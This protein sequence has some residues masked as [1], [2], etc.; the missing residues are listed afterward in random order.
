MS[1]IK[2]RN[3]ISNTLREQVV[4]CIFNKNESVREVARL[5][6]LKK[7]TIYGI[8]RVFTDEKRIIK[9]IQTGR[10]SSFNLDQE[11]R[12]C[13]FWKLNADATL[14]EC[15]QYIDSS[16][17]VFDGVKVSLTTIDRI[18]KKHRVTYKQLTRVPHARNTPETIEKRFRYVTD[19]ID[20]ENED[21]YLIYLD[22]FGVNLH[23]RRSRGRAQIG[24]PAIINTPT[25]RGNN[26][27]TCAAISID[28]VVHFKSQFCPFNHGNFLEFLDGLEK[29]LNKE[30]NNVLIMDNVRF[31]HHAL[32][33]EWI[34]R[35][36]LSVLYLPPYSPFLNPIEE[37]FSKVSNSI[38]LSRSENTETLLESVEFAFR[39]IT[40][41]NIRGWFRH[42]RAYH[43]MCLRKEPILK[44]ANDECPQFLVVE[45]PPD[46]EEEELDELL[47]H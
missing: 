36:N 45:R 21:K 16:P 5:L 33:K 32:V 40:S 39:S 42:S 28:G 27:S 44:E 12:I 34:S 17:T 41:E 43:S 26:L 31:H 37:T 8:C 22:E 19:L 7:R 2:R 29:L 6:D 46:V 4:N 3:K 25:Q 9:K 30:L 20:L 47:W 38:A 23:T 18:L 10:K 14:K 13:S 15:Q 11:L 1:E 35:N 24:K